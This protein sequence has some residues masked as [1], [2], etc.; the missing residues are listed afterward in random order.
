M[1]KICTALLLVAAACLTSGCA[2]VLE[3]S[4]SSVRPH[5]S[6]Y[7]E[8]GASSSALRVE[9]YQSLVNGLLV[10]VSNQTET[11]VVRL[12]GYA[13]QSAVVADMDRAVT[14]VTMEDPLGGYLV[15]YVTYECE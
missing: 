9:D 10:L 15:E 6:Q 8:E 4:Y 7:W 13:E 5:T 3:R 14:E 11:G 1:K 12:Y 2:A